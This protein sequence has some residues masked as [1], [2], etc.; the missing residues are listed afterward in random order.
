MLSCSI[1]S[2]SATPWTVGLEVVSSSVHEIFQVRI[3]EV[4]PF[5]TQRD[6]PSS[7]RWTPV[8]AG[9]FFPVASPGNPEEGPVLRNIFGQSW[10]AF[11][12]AA[13]CLTCQAE[14]TFA[15]FPPLPAKMCPA[16]SLGWGCGLLLGLLR[17]WIL[18][19]RHLLNLW[20]FDCEIK[21]LS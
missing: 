5:S 16:N 17:S 6:L 3:L 14:I 21:E 18:S 2:N 13:G 19:E 1:V 20:F 12:S 4:W 7:R 8:S 10:N 15:G 11:C 9:T